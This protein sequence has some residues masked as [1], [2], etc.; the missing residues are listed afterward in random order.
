MLT[1]VLPYHIEKICRRLEEAR[2]FYL[3]AAKREAR[4][5]KQHDRLL[6]LA[7]I[8]NILK[9]YVKVQ[10]PQVIVKEHKTIVPI[11]A[12]LEEIAAKAKV[13]KTTIQ[14]Y[15]FGI[16]VKTKYTYQFQNS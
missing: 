8:T 4:N 1:D 9:Y 11:N 10:Q 12:S 14:N 15:I 13:S 3:E 6:S 2:R 16:G 7:K 5:S